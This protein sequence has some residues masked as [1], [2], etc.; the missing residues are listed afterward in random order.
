M[1][2]SEML[3]CFLANLLWRQSYPNI[4]V[5]HGTTTYLDHFLIWLELERPCR[6]RT[7]KR[8]FRFEALWLGETECHNIIENLWVNSS[9]SYSFGDIMQKIETCSKQLEVWNIKHF[10]NVQQKL[11]HAKNKL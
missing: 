2:V 3:D 4:V 5:T 6:N 11:T 7:K 8:K 10:G 1:C 9:T